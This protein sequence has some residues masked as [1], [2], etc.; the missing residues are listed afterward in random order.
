[1]DK[2]KE[3]LRL[4]NKSEKCD[5]LSIAGPSENFKVGLNDFNF[6]EVLGMGTFGK[7]MLAEKKDTDE[8][9][10]VKVQKKDA[11]TKN[12]HVDSIMSEKRILILAANHPFLTELHSCFQT[13]DR[14]FFVMEYL[15]GG[16]LLF[17]I[18]KNG[19]FN[20]QCTAFYAAEIIIALQFLH[21]NGVIHRDLKLENVLLDQEGHSKLADFG[22]CKVTFK[23]LIFI[24]SML[25]KGIIFLRRKKFSTEF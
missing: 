5:N 13:P 8:L 4:P 3:E 23:Q 16:D 10:A 7:V 14:L 15:N 20:E 21:T 22:M 12:K 17:H 11:I 1:M 9:Y 6:I 25:T 19:K 2:S 24:K 18:K